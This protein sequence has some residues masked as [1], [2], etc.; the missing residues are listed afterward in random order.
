MCHGKSKELKKDRKEVFIEETFIM[1]KAP[2]RISIIFHMKIFVFLTFYGRKE[3]TLD[4]ER[5]TKAGEIR[6]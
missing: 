5:L 4:N 3:A 1:V 2:F 6:S